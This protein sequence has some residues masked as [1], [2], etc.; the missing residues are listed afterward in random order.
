MLYYLDASCDCFA[1]VYYG[2]TFAENFA[3][4]IKCLKEKAIF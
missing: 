4:P 3:F 2:A 1:Y